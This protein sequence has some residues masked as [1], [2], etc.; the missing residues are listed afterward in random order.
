[1]NLYMERDIEVLV[2]FMFLV[3]A[4]VLGFGLRRFWGVVLPLLLVFLSILWTLGFQQLLGMPLNLLTPAVLVMLIAM[5]SDYAVHSIN[6]YLRGG[7]VRRA[8][9][10]IS[11]P[12][13]MS[14]VTTIAGLLTFGTT[15]IRVLNDFGYELAIGLGVACFLTVTFLIVMIRIV[16]VRPEAEGT[17]EGPGSAREGAAAEQQEEPVHLFGRFLEGLT[18]RLFRRPRLFLA[19]V[20][21]VVVIMGLGIPRLSSNVDFVTFLPEDSPPREGHEILRNHF[22]GIYPVTL[23][24][25]GDIEEPS[26]LTMQLRME[27]LLRSHPQLSGFSSLGS[28]IAEMNRMLTGTYAIPV[29]RAGVA[30]LWLLMESEPYLKPL[31]N[32]ER[33]KALVSALIRDSATEVMKETAYFVEDE[34]S[35]SLGAKDEILTLEPSRLSGKDR[36]T[37]LRLQWRLAARQLAALAAGYDRDSRFP[38]SFFEDRIRDSW[39]A[40]LDMGWG[41][42]L[43]SS[44]REYLRKEAIQLLDEPVQQQ[45]IVIFREH[46][47]RDDPEMWMPAVRRVLLTRG[48]MDPQ[49]AEVLEEGALWRCREVLRAEQVQR[50]LDTFS[51]GLPPALVKNEDFQRRAKGVVWDLLSERPVMLASSCTAVAGID[52]AVVHRVPVRIDHSGAPS[53]FRKFDQLLFRSQFQSLL[54][55]TLVVLILVSITQRSIRRGI[56]SIV[57]VLVPLEMVIGL[58]GWMGIPLDFGTALF[59]AL[60]IGLGIDGCIHVLHY[61]AGLNGRGLSEQQA[62]VITLRHVGRAV[63]TANITTAAGFGVLLFSITRAVRNFA[64]V[65]VLAILLVTASIITLLPV[66]IKVSHVFAT[67]ARA[68][69]GQPPLPGGSGP[70]PAA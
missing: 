28:T 45:V 4:L 31:V 36:A 48:S 65:S 43:E 18:V 17:G 10:E 8:G 16:R 40:A 58:M 33:D 3:M 56:V 50:I 34:L 11:V 27:N 20:A 54:L 70:G 53:I 15:Q 66:L 23:Y 1:M 60:I 62:M 22:G 55:A 13:L 57:A 41:H 38:V 14:A 59:G 42:R 49:D 69:P 52:G 37:L 26:V 24:F 12:I 46:F 61:E 19:G 44:L 29:D 7:D 30:S 35:L 9:S 67:T 51:P 63:L 39:K 47:P 5:G 6:H 32:D 2:P 21:V 68:A 64:G 25:R